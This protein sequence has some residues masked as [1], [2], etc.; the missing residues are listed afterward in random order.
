MLSSKSFQT[1]DVT[2]VFFLV[3]ADVVLPSPS[4]TGGAPSAMGGGF[5]GGSTVA[6]LLPILTVGATLSIGGK[7]LYTTGVGYVFSTNSSCSS[8]C[9]S[10]K[11]PMFEWGGRTTKPLR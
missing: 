9:E 7:K 11:S 6:V 1:L 10:V 4:V 8:G 3:R 5:G 2:F